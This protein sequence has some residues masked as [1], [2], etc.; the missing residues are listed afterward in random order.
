MAKESELI[1]NHKL[2][3]FKLIELGVG[4]VPVSDSIRKVCEGD[5]PVNVL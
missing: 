1:Q 5:N 4:I 3:R 2:I